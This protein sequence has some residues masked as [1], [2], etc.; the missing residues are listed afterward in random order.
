MGQIEYLLAAVRHGA[1]NR[2]APRCGVT[3]PSLTCA[4][5]ALERELGGA[6]FRRGPRG[7][8]LTEFGRHLQPIFAQIAECAASA[9]RAAEAFQDEHRTLVAVPDAP[10][11]SERSQRLS[12]HGTAG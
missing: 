4:I 8:E 10:E 11:P 5:R 6:L 12:R 1:F 3:Q 7:S 2:A 9:R